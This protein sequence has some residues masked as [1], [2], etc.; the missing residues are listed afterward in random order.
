[1]DKT[2]CPIVFLDT[3]VLISAFGSC[4]PLTERLLYYLI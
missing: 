2:R 4:T 1:M 3:N